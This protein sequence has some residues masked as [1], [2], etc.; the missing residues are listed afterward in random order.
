[1]NTPGRAIV[2]A[3]G[4][5]FLKKSHASGKVTPQ[6]SNEIFWVIPKAKVPNWRFRQELE[7]WYPR[8]KRLTAEVLSPNITSL[9]SCPFGTIATSDESEIVP[10]W[11]ISNNQAEQDIDKDENYIHIL[12]DN[13]RNEFVGGEWRIT[14]TTPDNEV[15]FQ[16]WIE[17]NM[18]N[19]PTEFAD[20]FTGDHTVNGIGNATLP[21]VVGSWYKIPNV[22]PP[23]YI[24]APTSSSGSSRNPQFSQKPEISAPGENITSAQALDIDRSD[25]SGTS[26]AAPHVTGVIALMFQQ[27]L[28]LPQPRTLTMQE[29]RDI[30]IDTVNKNPAPAGN[31]D[32]DPRLGFGRVN[33]LNA[34]K[35]IKN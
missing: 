17:H 22:N 13:R 9:E 35:K 6:E 3:A 5:D 4:N 19:P 15:D 7:I 25:L 21:I 16:A 30:L 29:I 10:L 24:P 1:M 18:S 34:L 27:G 26:A 12:V 33:A 23:S 20:N 14:L 11:V 2:I 8:D 31:G 28:N 32:Y